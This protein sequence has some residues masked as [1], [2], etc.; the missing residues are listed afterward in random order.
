[1]LGMDFQRLNSCRLGQSGVAGKENDKVQQ[2]LSMRCPEWHFRGSLAGCRH[3]QCGFASE[4]R[5]ESATR[6]IH[7]MLG[8]EFQRLTGCRH[9]QCGFTG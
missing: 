3:G 5:L 7:E 8:V 4:E 2:E 1:M 9:G 6:G